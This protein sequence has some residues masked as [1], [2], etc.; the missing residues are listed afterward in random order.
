[1]HTGAR[2]H[3]RHRHGC[4][5]GLEPTPHTLQQR[6][7]VTELGHRFALGSVAHPLGIAV[8]LAF[9]QAVDEQA[10]ML[11]HTF[12][13]RALRTLVV[14]EPA[15][16]FA[17]GQRLRV[18]AAEHSA[19]VLAVGARQRHEYARGRPARH[20]RIAY[21]LQQ[22]FGQSTEQHQAS[23]D[24]A[25]VAR[26]LACRV[27][28]G[29]SMGVDQFAQ[30]QRFLDGHE[31]ARARACEQLCQR[32]TDGAAPAL[33]QR[34]VAAQSSQRGHAPVAV[35]EHQAKVRGLAGSNALHQLTV[36]LGRIGQAPHGLRIADARGRE[37]QLQAVQIDLHGL[38][39]TEPSTV[40]CKLRCQGDCPCGAPRSSTG[41]TC[42]ASR[43]RR[44][45]LRRTT[46]WH[47]RLHQ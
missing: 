11:D 40:C 42:H 27:A 39:T 25:H 12:A 24:P 43:L 36:G 3:Q 17:R 31:R 4:A 37:A 29:Q 20:A 18:Q 2:A 46:L 21:R 34:G 14:I 8:A 16:Q 6:V 44:G 32:L 33:H 7:Q 23:L 13:L 28:L 47:S 30:Q 22:G 26:A 35:D 41:A 9:V 19:R 5:Q 15:P 45:K 1:M 10:W 38:R